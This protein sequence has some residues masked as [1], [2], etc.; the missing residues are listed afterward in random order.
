MIHKERLEVIPILLLIIISEAIT[1]SSIRYYYL[2]EDVLYFLTAIFG[3]VLVCIFLVVAYR[4]TQFGLTN[5]LWSALSIIVMLSIGLIVF[6]ESI[7]SHDLLGV[8]FIFIGFSI[9]M[10]YHING[11]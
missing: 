9:I 5:A 1:Q 11:H 7:P 4:R 2:T 3:Y 6:K 8:F 10:F